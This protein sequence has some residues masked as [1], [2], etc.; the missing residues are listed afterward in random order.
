MWRDCCSGRYAHQ[1]DPRILRDVE[2]I[3]VERRHEA[4]VLIPEDDDEVVDPARGQQVEI[5]F[6]VFLI[7][8]AT[9]EVCTLHGKHRDAAFCQVRLLGD[10]AYPRERI[11]GCPAP[12]SAVGRIERSVHQA[13]RIAAGERHGRLSLVGRTADRERL[14]SAFAEACQNIEVD[15]RRLARSK[16]NYGQAL[17]PERLLQFGDPVLRRGAQ[18]TFDDNAHPSSGGSRQRSH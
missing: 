1:F 2:K 5:S 13:A 18:L 6:P 10:F 9:L 3:R 17:C 16:V 12:T 11:G 15:S 8:Q 14:G 7:E 4:A